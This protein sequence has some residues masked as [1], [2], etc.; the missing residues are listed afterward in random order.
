MKTFTINLNKKQIFLFLTTIVV[1][2]LIIRLFDAYNEV[3]F[4]DLNFYVDWSTK[5]FDDGIFNIYS[6]SQGMEV[7][8]PPVLIFFFYITGGI[9]RNPNIMNFDPNLMLALKMW[10][11]IF[12]VAIIVLI[13]FVLKKQ[14]EL[15]ALAFSAV[16]AVNP[17]IIF[18]SSTWGQTDSVMIFML[19]LTFVVLESKRPIL[20]TVLFALSCMTKFQCAYFAPVFI[21]FMVFSKYS[22]RQL[23][24]SAATGVITV[25]T[26]FLPFMIVSGIAL[27]INIY[28]GGFDKY[29][30][31]T[32]YAFNLYG[33]FNFNFHPDDKIFFLG[34]TIHDFGTMMTVIALIATVTLF[35]IARKKCPYLLSFFIMNTIFIF[36]SRMHERY[37]IPV[38]IFL[39]IAAARHKSTKL[40]VSFILTTIIVFLNHAIAF[41]YILNNRDNRVPWMNNIDAIFKWT[42]IANVLL[43]FITLFVTI[44]C[45]YDLDK[46]FSDYIRQLIKKMLGGVKLAKT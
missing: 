38:L 15:L 37:Q 19:L 29:K 3:H 10:Q 13:Y 34:M 41:E 27:P 24:H 4:F 8:Y 35:L 14:N 32:L 33:C 31:A 12:D 21:L 43:Y 42:S 30:Y 45:L 46:K 1:F 36:A 7:D 39:L 26:V 20:A 16:W 25:L 18:N 40:F 11:I 22:L 23:I 17:A 2:G 44:L 5:A 6:V 9:L 28:T